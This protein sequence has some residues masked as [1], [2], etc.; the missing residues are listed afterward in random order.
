LLPAEGQADVYNVI[1]AV[2]RFQSS[3]DYSHFSNFYDCDQPSSG[4]VFILQP[5]RAVYDHATGQWKLR[6]KGRLQIS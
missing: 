6:S 5:A 1:P 3:Q 2:P 4:E